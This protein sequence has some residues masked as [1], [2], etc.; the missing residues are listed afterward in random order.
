M[1]ENSK[2]KN[3]SKYKHV[4]I[5][6]DGACKGNPGTGGWGSIIVYKNTEKELCGGEKQTTN[7]RMEL[8][9]IISALS[10]LKEP[11]NVTITTDSKYVV[12]AIEKSWL[13]NWEKN[14]WIKSDRKPVLN[15]DLW[16]RLLEL[17]D[18]HQVRFTWIKGHSGHAYNERCDKLASDYAET[19][20]KQ[21]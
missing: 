10:I 7:N 1:L 12:D 17:L 18:V 15:V 5:Y 21:N 11:C 8:I 3:I 6:S 9:A 19:L 14:N 4:D 13:S 20:K 16:K 2:S